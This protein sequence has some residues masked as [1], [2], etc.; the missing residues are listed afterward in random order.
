MA[1]FVDG[2]AAGPAALLVEGEAGIGKT[3][4]WRA[5]VAAARQR[6]CR[7]AAATAVDDE[8]DLAFGVLRDLLE[9]IPAESGD[10]LP[11]VQR[12]ALDIALLRSVHLA[13]AADPHAVSAAVLGVVRTV[14]ASTP[15]VV[16]VDDAGWLDRSSERVL[17]YVVR[18]LTDEPVGILAARRPDAGHQLPLGLD[19]P[20]VRDRLRRLE[21]GPLDAGALHTLLFEQTGLVLPR[22]IIR[23]IY[24]VCGGNP[25]YALEMA[26]AVCR[27]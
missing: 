21:L 23:Q 11:P 22:R 7:V 3:T 14:A 24:R 13:T 20:P 15:L 16:A 5:A 26:R 4:V 2:L 18:R 19:R 17:R 8:V 12:E 10:A 27:R 25:L 6:G 1:A 9:A